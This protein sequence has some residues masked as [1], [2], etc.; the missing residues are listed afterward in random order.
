LLHLQ[1]VDRKASEQ[2]LRNYLGGFGFHEDQAMQPVAPFS[3][4]EKARL[5]LALLVYQR[6]NLLLLD[7]PTN[8][9]DLEMRYAVGEALQD[10][11]GAMVIVSHDRHLLRITTDE[12]WLVH[13]AR[14]APFAGSLDDYPQWL[15]SQ[16]R[17]ESAAGGGM[18][19][20]AQK[21]EHTAT[22]RKDRKR[23]QAEQRKR[24]QPLRRQLLKFEQ[25]MEEL[26]TRQQQLNQLL[27]DPELYDSEKKSNLK[28]ILKDKGDVERDLNDCEQRWLKMSEQ[29]EAAENDETV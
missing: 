27:T 20:D 4:G 9:L 3:G 8:H 28:R 7:E 18:P 19:A 11:Q 5:V 23:L 6:P 2:S 21:A 1:R 25:K 29:L 10:F 26:H 12:F 24:L 22:A 14:V 17:C 15:T 13:N 16:R